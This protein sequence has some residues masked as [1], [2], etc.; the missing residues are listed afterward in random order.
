MANLPISDKAIVSPN[1]CLVKRG[2]PLNQVLSS[3]IFKTFKF[4]KIT[5]C[6]FFY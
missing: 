3:L 1:Q 2:K 4:S 6:T 5:I